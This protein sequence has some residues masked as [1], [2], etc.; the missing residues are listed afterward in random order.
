MLNRTLRDLVVDRLLPG[1]QTPGQYIGGEP[2]AV[3]KD[4]RSLRGKLCLA[5]PDAYTIGMSHHGLQVLYAVMNRRADWACERAF[6]PMPDL[7]ALLRQ[8]H[9]PL[10]SLENFT[11]LGEFDVLGFTLQYDLCATNVLTMLDLGGIPLAADER[12]LR[13]PLV[14]AGGPGAANP[15]PL[16]R[17]IDLFLLGDGEESLPEVCEGWLEARRAAPERAA[18]LAALAAR[19]PY[20]YVPRFYE[21]QYEGGRAVGVRPLRPDVPARIEPAVLANLDAMPLPTAPVVPHVQ[22]VQ[23]R[24]TIEIMRGCPWRCRFCQST[25][26]KRPVRMRKVETI[27]QAAVESYR[28][29]GLNEISLLGL[30]SGDYSDLEPLLAR[31]HEVFRPLGVS[32]SLPSLR[33]NRRWRS[34]GEMLNTD[35]R[36]GLTLAPEAARQDMR[37]LLGKE[38]TDDDLLAGCRRA[39]ENGFTRVKLYFM[40]GLPGERPADLDGIIELAESISRLGQEVLGRPA[41][42]VANVSNFVPKPQTPFQWNG[43]Q[44]REYFQEAHGRLRRRKRLRSVTLRCHDLD[45]SLLEG[46]LCRGDRRVGAAIQ[47]AWQAGA[48]LDA[49][50]ERLRPRLWWQAL[51]ESGIDVE[52]LLHSPALPAA[53]LPWDHIGIHQGREYLRREAGLACAVKP[54]AASQ[55]QELGIRD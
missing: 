23:D 27:V 18:A 51:A 38:I 40:C 17:F 48:R 30:S 7:E 37:E 34:L 49:W 29:T 52:S 39:M 43:M 33:V 42:V 28:N 15:E 1:V 16:A 13:H 47:R 6:T 19:L 5:F 53:G 14:I 26:L 20:V 21:P 41:A 55:E 4:Y 50:A 44:R 36:D 12:T 9:L 46:V 32:V 11:P 25:T 2:G 8:A 3:A 35:R 22:C 45:A 24:I 10:A 31:L 54:L